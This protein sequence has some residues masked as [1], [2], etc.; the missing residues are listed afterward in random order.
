MWGNVIHMLYSVILQQLLVL[1][2]TSLL[3]LTWPSYGSCICT[4]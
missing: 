4:R 1:R 2:V 3:P